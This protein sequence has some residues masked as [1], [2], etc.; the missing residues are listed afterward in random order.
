MLTSVPRLTQHSA[1]SASSARPRGRD[2]AAPPP[3][4]LS[5]AA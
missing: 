3:N 1:V 2:A 4:R 5:A